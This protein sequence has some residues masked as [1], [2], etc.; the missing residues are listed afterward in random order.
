MMKSFT[1][2]VALLALTTPGQAAEKSQPVAVYLA[3]PAGP[4]QGP[5]RI[6][7]TRDLR[8]KLSHAKKEIRLVDRLEDAVVIVEVLDRTETNG[9]KVVPVKLTIGAYTTTLQGQS[10][11]MMPLMGYSGTSTW[12]MAALDV[13]SQ[14]KQFLRANAQ[15]LRK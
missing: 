15:K 4:F 3:P 11:S 12:Q 7:S 1:L 9:E 14:I 6:A 5:Q 8:E 10:T 2:A 13:T